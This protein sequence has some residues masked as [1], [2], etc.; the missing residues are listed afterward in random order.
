MINQRVTC[1]NITTLT[2]D[3]QCDYMLHLWPALWLVTGWCYHCDRHSVTESWRWRRGWTRHHHHSHHIPGCC[4][5]PYYTHLLHCI[6]NTQYLHTSITFQS[7]FPFLCHLSMLISA[8]V[9]GHRFLPIQA[10][11]IQYTLQFLHSTT[12]MSG[13]ELAPGPGARHLVI[14]RWKHNCTAF[15]TFALHSPVILHLVNVNNSQY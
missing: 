15:I 4:P 10:S 6:L 7:Q 8:V 5:Y 14:K 9:G 13:H 12:A 3:Q 2:C 11:S 1:Y